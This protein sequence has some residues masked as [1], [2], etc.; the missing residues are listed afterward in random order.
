MLSA[1]DLYVRG[2]ETAVASWEAYARASHDAAV[3]RS[4]GVAAAV[5]PA[6]P[7][8]SVYNN[9]VLERDLGPG[10]RATAL[11][12]MEG[13][14]ASAGVERFAAW[15]HESDEALRAD[16]V[17]RGYVLDTSTR[18]MGMVLDDVRRPELELE[19]APSSWSDYVRVAELPTGLLDAVD[20]CA[21]H[22]R[23]ALLAGESVASGIAF[24]RDG[25]CGIYNVGTLAHAR[26]RGIGTALTAVLAH[27]AAARG[28]E[29]ASLQA[30]A[31]AERVYAAVGFRDLGRI[32]EYV[33]G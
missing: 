16:V 18:A 15:V 23:I 4:P 22:V 28:C 7:A 5:F 10:A 21:F 20:P 1:R 9:A 25:D 27:D 26:R 17:A 12:A 13:A 2:A 19:L 8:R 14:Y 31:T 33:P 3:V 6:E 32:L 29:T 24:D 11:D 30:T